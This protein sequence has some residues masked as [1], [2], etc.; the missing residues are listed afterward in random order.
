MNSYMS[1]AQLKQMAK[2][3]LYGRLGT[4]IG[5]F[6][7]HMTVYLVLSYAVDGF[8]TNTVLGVILYFGIGFAIDLFISIFTAGE[9]FLYLNICTGN[10]GTVADVFYGFKGFA[11]KTMLL[12]FIPVLVS[13]LVSIPSFL[14]FRLFSTVMPSTEEMLA[15]LQSSNVQPLMELSEKLFPIT[16]LCCALGL[17]QIVITLTVDV[18]FS[19]TLFFMLDYPDCTVMD[20]LKNSIRIMK[21]NWG[22]YL[23]ILLSFI[24]WYILGICTFYISFAWSYPYQKA[25][26]TN[27]YLELIQNYNKDGNTADGYNN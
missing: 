9:N 18:I 17:F 4:V 16:S 22:R 6:L 27:F 5:A 20:T 8:N 13:T 1:S 14:L 21:G 10:E 11:G 12:R 3:K 2:A 19:Q 25:T 26:M 24:P 7:V 15:M 23:Y